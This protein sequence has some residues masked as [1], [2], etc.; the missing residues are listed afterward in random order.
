MYRLKGAFLRPELV[1]ATKGRTP[2]FDH[3]YKNILDAVQ[4]Y[5]IHPSDSA[6]HNIYKAI[7]SLCVPLLQLPTLDG[8]SAA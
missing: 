1:A 8:K 3:Y 6:V 5:G 7:A 2:D 4:E